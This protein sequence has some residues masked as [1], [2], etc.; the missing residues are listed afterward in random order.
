MGT[1]FFV[2][3]GRAERT[4]FFHRP[5]AGRPPGWPLSLALPCPCEKPPAHVR[6]R[7]ALPM[8]ARAARRLPAFPVGI[9]TAPPHWPPPTPRLD[10]ALLY[11]R[12]VRAVGGEGAGLLAVSADA[13]GPRRR[14]WLGFLWANTR[15]RGA[16]GV[17]TVGPL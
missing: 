16:H 5:S 13:D 14:L 10:T 8:F 1:S 3:L 2:I 11:A 9:T 4:S 12:A 15:P 6:W 17:A 7:V